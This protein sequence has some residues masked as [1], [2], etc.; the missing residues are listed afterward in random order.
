MTKSSLKPAKND[1]RKSTEAESRFVVNNFNLRKQK[2]GKLL[3]IL[4]YVNVK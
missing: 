4:N 3:I 1:K 2:S